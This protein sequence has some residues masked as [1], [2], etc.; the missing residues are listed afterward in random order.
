MLDADNASNDEASADVRQAGEPRPLRP[1]RTQNA[2]SAFSP[3]ISCV[4]SAPRQRVETAGSL[5]AP[6]VPQ[7]MHAVTSQGFALQVALCVM[8]SSLHCSLNL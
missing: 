8:A 7:L 6:L 3:S 5:I 1:L 2:P 4:P